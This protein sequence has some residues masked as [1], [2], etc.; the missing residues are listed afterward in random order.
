MGNC[1][2]GFAPVTPDRH[3]WLIGLIPADASGLTP[4]RLPLW[5]AASATSR[6]KR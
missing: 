5:S 3:D 2:V 6:A 1:G 4:Y